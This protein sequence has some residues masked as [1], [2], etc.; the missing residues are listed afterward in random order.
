MA[1]LR[2]RHLAYEI[3]IGGCKQMAGMLEVGCHGHVLGSEVLVDLVDNE[4]PAKSA[5]NSASLLEAWMLVCR[6][7][8]GLT[9][10]A[11]GMCV[12]T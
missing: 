11:E 12:N 10:R 8:H 6:E 7:S 1:I 5:S 4:L 2:A 3:S 9:L